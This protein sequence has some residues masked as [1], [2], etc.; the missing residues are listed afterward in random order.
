MHWAY[1]KSM[2]H[3]DCILRHLVDAEEVDDDG[4]LHAA[5]VAWRGLALL[6]TL[7]EKRDQKLH[8][9]REMQRKRAAQG[10]V[11]DVSGDTKKEAA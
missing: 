11:G 7:L 4:L 10:D 1:G 8:A 6:Q 2:D 9:L 5:K 3:A